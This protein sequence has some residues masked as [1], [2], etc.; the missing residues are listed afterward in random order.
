M[1][2][3]APPGKRALIFVVWFLSFYNFAAN[4]MY[5]KMKIGNHELTNLKK[6]LW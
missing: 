3:K 1:R 2:F 5:S 4:F 6:V